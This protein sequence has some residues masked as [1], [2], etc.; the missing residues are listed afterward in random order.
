[1]DCGFL[2]RVLSL[3]VYPFFF[4]HTLPNVE[5]VLGGEEVGYTQ[6][7]MKSNLKC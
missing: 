1:M 6:G 7:S 2:A 5:T 4:L 3:L